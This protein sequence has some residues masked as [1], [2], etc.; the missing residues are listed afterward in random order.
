[1]IDSMRS[2]STG[3]TLVR[4]VVIATAAFA[5]SACDDDDPL[6]PG[7]SHT[8][9]AD[10]AGG[11]GFEA[12]TGDLL[13]TANSV[14]FSADLEIAGAEPAA[15]F[16]WGIFA[17]ACDDVGDRVGAASLYADVVADAN[18]AGVEEAIGTGGM[19]SGDDYVAQLTTEVAAADVVVACAALVEQAD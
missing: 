18:G 7:P 17:G 15:V 12:V 1:M 8:W 2:V 5:A 19:V 11:A 14:S 10:L 3:R 13:V 16:S 6:D 9:A 4:A